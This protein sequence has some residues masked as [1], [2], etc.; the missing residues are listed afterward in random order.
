MVAEH[1]YGM[2][3]PYKA[4]IWANIASVL[5][6]VE[7]PDSALVLFTMAK[8]SLEPSLGADHPMLAIIHENIMAVYENLGQLPLTLEGTRIAQRIMVK[9]AGP[10][11]PD[12]PII[13][14][15][16]GTV[17]S[18]MEVPDSALHYFDL[19]IRAVERSIGPDHLDAIPCHLNHERTLIDVGLYEA[20][21]E[22]AA[23]R[24]RAQRVVGE[25]SSE[26][27][28]SLVDLGSAYLYKVEPDSALRFLDG[29]LTHM[30][31]FPDGRT[32]SMAHVQRDRSNAFRIKKVAVKA[33]SAAD[34]SLA[35]LMDA[36]GSDHYL[37]GLGHQERAHVNVMSGEYDHAAQH[38]AE[39]L[40]IAT[41]PGAARS[42]TAFEELVEM[43]DP[44]L[45]H[46]DTTA[47]LEKLQASMQDRTSA[48]AAWGLYTIHLARGNR[49]TALDHLVTYARMRRSEAGIQ[50]VV[51]RMSATLRTLATGLGR[52]D[53]I[54][55][56]QLD[57]P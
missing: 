34:P 13:Y 23:T 15:S 32:P 27:I 39:A 31:A 33:P 30:R 8:M 40:R 54:Q 26:Y 42:V 55:E 4:Q 56:F 19:C 53:V 29:A 49:A 1:I 18:T 51:A 22:L 10:D 20:I 17:F 16:R 43:A 6:E 5:E 28:G 52:T 46:G 41:G 37:T 57:T 47:A 14:K 45:L 7:R 50:P 3:H 12:M 44:D 24:D 36:V 11:H 48:D 9:E 38:F 35:I 2:D 21:A 25:L